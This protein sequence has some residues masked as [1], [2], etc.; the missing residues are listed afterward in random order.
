MLVSAIVSTYNSEK[1]I[2]GCIEDL[3][4]QTISDRLEI[5]II[6]SGSLQNERTVVEELQSRFS[7]IKYIR[8]EERE[9]VYKA[10]N[11]A[12]EAASGKYLTNAN[13]D[14]R[15]RSD[16]YERMAEVLEAKPEISLVYAD[17]ATTTEENQTLHTA[18]ITGFLKWPD[19]DPKLLF[20]GCYVG[21]QPMWRKSLH[22]LYGYFDPTFRSA[23]DYEFWLRLAINSERFYHLPDVLGLYLDSLSGIEN[24]HMGLSNEEGEK[25]R[26]RHWQSAWSERPLADCSY[27]IQT[28]GRNPLVTV[29]IPTYNRPELLVHSLNSLIAQDYKNWEAIVINDGGSSVKSLAES[30][31]SEGRIR[32]LEH[33]SSFGPATARN[34][35]LRLAKGK[36]IC[37]LDDD[38]LFLPNHISTVVTGLMKNPDAVVYTDAE[39][40]T[41]KIRDGKREEVSRQPCKDSIGCIT[42]PREC[43]YVSNF[44]PINT[45]AHL[46][47]CL[48]RCGFFDEKLPSH[49]DWELILRFSKHFEFLHLPV[50]TAEIRQRSDTIDNVSRRQLHTY[51]G[52]FNTIYKRYNDLNTDYVKQGRALMIKR[53]T[54]DESISSLSDL[55][56][57]IKRLL[58][59]YILWRFRPK[60]MQAT[61]GPDNIKR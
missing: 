10:W 17:V 38:D 31:D 60:S 22:N 11:R 16:A 24:S 23:G 29:I 47:E 5:I 26:A 61:V 41:E 8:T 27:F 48:R 43:L 33:F 34:T 52:V 54:G 35:G 39:V 32:Y 4:A 19:F 53:I 3:E 1:F 44:I 40:V 37:Y 56:K 2:R 49:E 25:A 51:L 14:D 59:R 28:L 9:T 15:H 36:I 55:T 20:E 57:T 21:P 42:R 18:D 6:D 46:R 30:V 50:I 13:T 12:I 7:N 58:D 45:C